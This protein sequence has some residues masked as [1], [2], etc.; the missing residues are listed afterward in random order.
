MPP[1]PTFFILPAT[2]PG[3]DTYGEAPT[4]IQAMPRSSVLTVGFD[5]E[6]W[7]NR[8]IR[9]ISY[10]ILARAHP[11]GALV[12]IG[13]S[14]SALGMLNLA[15]DRPGLFS[16]ILLFD[17]PL[18]MRNLPPWNTADFYD[19]GAWEQDLPILNLP[20]IRALL[21][22]T[23]LIHIAGANFAEQH[24][25]FHRALSTMPPGPPEAPAYV[26]HREP[27]LAHHWDSGWLEQYAPTVFD[28]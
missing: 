27:N 6:V 22:E 3:D 5:C 16:A 17:A 21:A 19:Q 15:L 13:F 26:Y 11:T 8:Q 1:P 24:D 14:K 25:E 12:G 2:E 7:Y 18:T 28:S 23:R 9:D 10:R 4:D 20:R